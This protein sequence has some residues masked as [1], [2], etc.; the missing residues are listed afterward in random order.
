MRVAASVDPSQPFVY[1]EELV[2]HT[3]ATANSD[4]ILQKS[5]FGDTTRD[6]CINTIGEHYITNFKALYTPM[7]YIVVVYRN[8]FEIGHFTFETNK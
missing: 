1:N 3:Y 4:E 8:N 6:Y 7:Q 2:I 5:R